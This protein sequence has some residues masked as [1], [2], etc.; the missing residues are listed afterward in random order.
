[1]L[2]VKGFVYGN[3]K[4]CFRDTIVLKADNILSIIAFKWMKDPLF[5]PH[6]ILKFLNWLFWTVFA[7]LYENRLFPKNEC[8]YVFYFHWIDMEE[9][10]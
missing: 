2:V 9:I 8:K 1:M 3:P 10:S 7:M 5:L 4:P 6:D